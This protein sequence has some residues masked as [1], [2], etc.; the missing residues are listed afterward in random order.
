M[1]LLKKFSFLL[2]L[3]S[4]LVC[5]FDYLGNDG[6]HIL[7]FITNPV[8]NHIVY[9]EPFRGWIIT[10]YQDANSTIHPIG[11][12][13]HIVTFLLLGLLIDTIFFMRKRSANVTKA[14]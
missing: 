9:I 3:V 13:F 8:L 14:D 10:V 2:T 4:I 7:F 12:F 11:Y 5:L 1:T 6:K